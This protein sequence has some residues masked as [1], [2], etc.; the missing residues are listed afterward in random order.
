MYAHGIAA[1]ALCEAYGV[2]K[3]PALKAP[4]EK[5][6]ALIIFAQSP[7]GGWRYTPKP[8]DA[9]TSVTGWQYMALHSARMAGLEVPE[10][11]FENARKWLDLAGGGKHG[12]L[13]GYT[14]P[15]NN[16]P[17]MIATGM[18][19]RQLDLVSPT[20]P[21]MIESAEALKMHPM[22]VRSPEFYGLYYATLAL[23]QHQGPIWTEWNDKLKEALPLLQKKDGDAA[24]SWDPTGGHTGAGGRVLSTT[25]STLSLEVYYRLLPMY[26]FGNK[27]LPPPKQKDE[28]PKK[29]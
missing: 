9:D 8:A 19:C 12:G 2:S 23:Y 6:I 28:I 18:F 27:D 1:I 24:G 4:A 10:A 21:R 25:L 13:Y 7:K 26:G 11:V 3:D 16:N 17:A 22:N 15:A 29:P 5:A 20:D 14:G